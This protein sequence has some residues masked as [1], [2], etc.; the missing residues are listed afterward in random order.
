MRVLIT[1]LTALFLAVLAAALLSQLWVNRNQ[2]LTEESRLTLLNA[3]RAAL[4]IKLQYYDQKAKGGS[5]LKL[6]QALLDT[7][8][9]ADATAHDRFFILL[10]GSHCSE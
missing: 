5:A 10:D 8:V 3:E 1:G 6:N 4:N 9:P 7:V 2:N